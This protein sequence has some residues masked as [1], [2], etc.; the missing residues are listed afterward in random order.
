MSDDTERPYNRITRHDYLGEWGYEIGNVPGRKSKA[1]MRVRP[2]Y[3]RP[4]A[5]FRDEDEAERFRAFFIEV[6]MNQ[7]VVHHGELPE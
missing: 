3:G 4:V 1:L 6:A 5:Y 2:G 7:R